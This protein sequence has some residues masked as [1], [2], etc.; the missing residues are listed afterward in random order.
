M[1][2]EDEDSSL[3]TEMFNVE[4]W[5]DLDIEMV[6]DS[7][8][9][10]HILDAGHDAPGYALKELEGSRQGKDFIVGNGKR[11]PNG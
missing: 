9:C 7:G 4:D 10:A 5:K 1:L 11:I 2:E 6:L 8:C 3:T